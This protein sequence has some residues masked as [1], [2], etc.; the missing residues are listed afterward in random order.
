ML[1][2]VRALL[3]LILLLL[4]GCVGPMMQ[5]PEPQEEPGEWVVERNPAVDGLI[6]QAA[7][8]IRLAITKALSPARNEACASTAGNRRCIYCWRGATWNWPNPGRRMNS[9]AKGFGLRHRAPYCMTP[10]KPFA[11]NRAK[12]M[13]RR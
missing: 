13:H 9:H 2:T 12:T 5:S 6:E 4:A 8:P 1:N 7:L 11:W 10:S 3:S